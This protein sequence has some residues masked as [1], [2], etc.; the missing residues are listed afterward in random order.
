VSVKRINREYRDAAREESTLHQIA[1]AQAAAA[2]EAQLREQDAKLAT[3]VASYKCAGRDR[4]IARAGRGVSAA[5]G[6]CS[7]YASSG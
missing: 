7:G 6:S 4:R 5:S 1:S 3:A 2:R